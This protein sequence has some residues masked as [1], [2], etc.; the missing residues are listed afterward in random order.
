VLG[1]EV[2]APRAGLSTTQTSVPPRRSAFADRR[3]VK[4]APEAAPSDST[5][6]GLQTTAPG[7]FLAGQ[8]WQ[9]LA[10]QSLRARD[11]AADSER[12]FLSLRTERASVAM[13]DLGTLLT[14]RGRLHVVVGVTPM[15]ATPRL[16]ELEDVESG[17]IRHVEWT[18][19][20]LDTTPGGA[21]DRE[22]STDEQPSD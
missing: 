3:R 17:R 5:S 19:P 21:R 7:S 15:G 8:V 22:D 16:L 9:T 14:Y 4:R 12:R 10:T 6:R 20:G 1:A 2:F 13:V 11:S 18:D